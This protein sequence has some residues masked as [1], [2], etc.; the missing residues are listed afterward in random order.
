MSRK[1]KKAARAARRAQGRALVKAVPI[2]AVKVVQRKHD[3]I[4]IPSAWRTSITY[5]G[6]CKA[7][8]R[9]HRMSLRSGP[10][11]VVDSSN[12]DALD[13]LHLLESE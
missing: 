6:S 8:S 5:L 3:G 1:T 13:L 12:A 4:R 9:L 11:L 7:G 2:P 10:C